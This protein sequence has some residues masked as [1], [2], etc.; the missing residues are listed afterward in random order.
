MLLPFL[1][2]Q[3]LQEE[4]A[5]QLDSTLQISGEISAKTGAFVL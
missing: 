4:K 1:C 5:V 2:R 3:D